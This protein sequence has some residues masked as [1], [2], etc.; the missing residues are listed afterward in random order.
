V[1]ASQPPQQYLPHHHYAGAASGAPLPWMHAGGAAVSG[2]L[3]AD[4]SGSLGPVYGHAAGPH[5]PLPLHAAHAPPPPHQQTQTQTQPQQ[6]QTQPQP[7]P[8][9]YYQQPLQYAQHAAP[10]AFPTSAPGAHAGLLTHS[11]PSID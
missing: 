10:Y 1:Y 11:L 7:Q 2:E 6:T 5:H 4:A 3:A 9:F 8:Q